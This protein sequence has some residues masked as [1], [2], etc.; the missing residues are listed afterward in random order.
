M[1]ELLND[2]QAYFET[3][4]LSLRTS[5]NDIGNLLTPCFR[6]LV[7]TRHLDKGGDVESFKKLKEA[8][9]KL[10]DPVRREQYLAGYDI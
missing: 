10:V 8:H 2:H 9:E 4:G 7:L 5:R 1:S 6:A 3:L